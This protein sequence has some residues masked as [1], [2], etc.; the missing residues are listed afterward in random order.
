MSTIGVFPSN[1]TK[2]PPNYDFKTL[3]LPSSGRNDKIPDIVGDYKVIQPI[4][5]TRAAIAEPQKGGNKVVIK[6][7][8]GEN[9][10]QLVLNLEHPN[11]CVPI[12][13]SEQNELLYCVYPYIDGYNMKV[14]AHHN[15]LNNEW[16]RHFLA[17][18]L[19]AL[20]YLHGKNLVHGDIKP[21]NIVLERSG[22][23]K[24]IDFET[25]RPISR[26]D[27]STYA[28]TPGFVPPDSK[29]DGTV[30]LPRVDIYA[31]A[32]TCHRILKENVIL[33]RDT[34][35]ISTYS[36]LA[37][38]DDLSL[39]YDYRL[40]SSIDK[41]LSTDP[42]ESWQSAAEWYAHISQLIQNSQPFDCTELFD[43]ITTTHI[44]DDVSTVHCAYDSTITGPDAWNYD[45]SK[46]YLTVPASETCLDFEVGLPRYS[47][48][49]NNIN[50]DPDFL[51][52]NTLIGPYRIKRILD[53]KRFLN[54]YLAI[55]TGTH[56]PVV[57]H[58]FYTCLLA[59]RNGPEVIYKDNLDSMLYI[60]GLRDF[61]HDCRTRLGIEHPRLVNVTEL[62]CALNTAYY[63]TPYVEGTPL[64]NADLSRVDE[65]HICYLLRNMLSVLQ[66]LEEK[67]SYHLGIEPSSIL[68]T[69]AGVPMLTHF[70]F[71]NVAHGTIIHVPDNDY[72]GRPLPIPPY[73]T[74]KQACLHGD[75]RSD[76]F[77]L[78]AT[79]Y[80]L[81]T[82][83]ELPHFD[84]WKD[85]DVE[86]LVGNPETEKR[87]SRAFLQSV[88]KALDEKWNSPA[89]W[90]HELD[91]SGNHI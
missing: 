51:A 79:M 35:L 47:A 90:L 2:F 53:K 14:I 58:E 91:C 10:E 7:C 23:H 21:S 44:N 89:E 27:S 77:A 13:I 4:L 57:L 6:C 74:E 66:A 63:V 68:I 86:R 22:C 71:K 24:L 17:D 85:G 40:L 32:A 69:S 3:K 8:T 76:L 87:F 82:G 49:Y 54:L 37:N 83:K 29:E 67:D 80:Y 41:A 64:K 60:R 12:E 52:Y 50:S 70:G 9:G 33:N 19:G 28:C 59:R 15:E 34:E 62:F 16:L 43:G 38:D 61:V 18:M 45:A 81:I 75:I 1:S 5:Y 55:D 42:A 84:A 25:V 48:L 36:S 39:K 31:L 11:I 26:N 30:S 46:T 56:E 88:E 65:E 20:I 78:G 72:S 73:F